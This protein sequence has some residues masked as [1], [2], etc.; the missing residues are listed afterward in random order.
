[1]AV[2]HRDLCRFFEDHDNSKLRPALYWLRVPAGRHAELGWEPLIEALRGSRD[3]LLSE[4]LSELLIDSGGLGGDLP[5][6]EADKAL[7]L[8]PD[9]LWALLLLV[10]AL[11][12]CPWA[13]FSA[14]LGWRIV[15]F[16]GLGAASVRSYAHAIAASG[17]N[18][19]G[20][21]FSK[22]QAEFVEMLDRRDPR[23]ILS[24]EEE[25]VLARLRTLFGDGLKGSL[26]D[27]HDPV[28]RAALA[29]LGSP[30]YISVVDLIPAQ[31]EAG[32]RA[33]RKQEGESG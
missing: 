1:M 28:A 21:R 2:S 22:P 8:L 10:D 20:L 32:R 9:R 5:G 18:D 33:A 30:V 11:E 6:P 26:K 4:L 3:P 25:E 31:P 13:A 19:K 16:L 29:Y 17:R 12:R 7:A 14:P 24:L 15:T 23:G 27:R